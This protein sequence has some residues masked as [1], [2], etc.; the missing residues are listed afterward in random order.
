[1]AGYQASHIIL[2]RRIST[3]KMLN[4]PLKVTVEVGNKDAHCALF[5]HSPE[6]SQSF[7]LTSYLKCLEQQLECADQRV[8]MLKLLLFRRV[9][10][11]SGYIVYL[12]A[13]MTGG[14]VH[15]VC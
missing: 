13:Y 12:L 10:S 11:L 3:S 4:H 15:I 2:C 7:A 9:P 14:G 5:L 1:M 6:N 8:T